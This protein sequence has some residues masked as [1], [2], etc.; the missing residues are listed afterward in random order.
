VVEDHTE[1]ALQHEEVY[2]VLSGRATF[3]LD[4][5]KLDAHAGTVVFVLDPAVRRSAT[6]STPATTVLAVGGRTG[7]AYSPSPWESFFYAE[8]HRPA[9]DFGAMADELG[10]ALEEFPGHPAV[11][12]HSPAPKPARA[13]TTRSA[14]TSPVPSSFV[15]SSPSR[16]RR[17][18]TSPLCASPRLADR[19]GCHPSGVTHPSARRPDRQGC[20][21]SGV[22]HPSARRPDRQGCHPSGVTPLG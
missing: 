1:T 14:P 19:Q 20:H 13:G 15:P 16:R 5:E 12:Y 22:T 2:V 3:V 18:T 17:T 4:G 10:A 11:L 8:R 9:G 6:A 7:E 21:P